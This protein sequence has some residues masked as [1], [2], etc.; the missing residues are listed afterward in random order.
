[1][2]GNRFLTLCLASLFALSGCGD[3][4]TT[5]QI[6][7]D[8]ESR[9]ETAA[10][11]QADNTERTK[12]ILF[13]GNSLTAGYGLEPDQAFPALIQDRLDSLNL[14][15]K[16]INAGV[17]GETTSGGKSRIDWLLKQPVDIF[18]LELGA[19]D[20][21]RGVSTEE[22]YKNLKVIIEK[23]R[24]KNPDVQVV[25]AGMQIPPSMGQQYAQDF[26]EIYTRIAEEED[27]ALIP[28]LLEG[29]AGDRELN[30]G[31]GIH[32]TEEGQ[33]IL[34]ENV[35]ETLEPIIRSEEA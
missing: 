25:L 34:A 19:N 6:Q 10:S 15:Y 18:V 5:E 23:V 35:W 8:K 22:T 3:V 21:L 2:T 16:A 24:A 27:V 30:Q 33:K 1:M 26:K 20:G 32:P 4:N 29:V 11:A 13:F 9:R 17:S 14:P 31:D 7:A 12:T 28:F